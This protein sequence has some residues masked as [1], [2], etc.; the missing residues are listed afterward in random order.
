MIEISRTDNRV[1]MHVGDATMNPIMGVIANSI[2][3]EIKI[4]ADDN[5]SLACLVEEGCYVNTTSTQFMYDC[6]AVLPSEIDFCAVDDFVVNYIS[7]HYALQWSTR[8]SMYSYNGMPYDELELAGLDIRSLLTEHWQLVSEGTPYKPSRDRVV[9]DI[10]NRIS[11]AIYVDNMPVSWC[12]LHRDNSLGMLYTLPEHRGKGYGAKVVIA[13]CIKL[14][15]RGQVPYSC[16][17]KGNDTA[18]NITSR[19]NVHYICDVTWCG[20]NKE[21]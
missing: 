2:D 13:Q 9:D 19:Y 10:T 8:C 11:S 16:V 5:G 17:I 6:V 3:S 14:L 7:S 4:W 20:I 12:V 1:S 18:E 15:D 21:I